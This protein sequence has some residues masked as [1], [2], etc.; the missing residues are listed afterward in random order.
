MALRA[1]S[2]LHD[3]V[4]R[5]RPARPAAGGAGGPRS[6]VVR[7]ANPL[8]ESKAGRSGSWTTKS[9]GSYLSG[10]ALSATRKN[11]ELTYTFTGRSAALLFSR[12]GKTGQAYVY[13]D[14]KKV[15]TIDTKS[16]SALYRQAV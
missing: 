12:G 8:A 1:L 14:G 16:S 5:A 9:Y 3:H 15:A 13:L 6:A 2:P 4:D 10:K 7:K 11:A